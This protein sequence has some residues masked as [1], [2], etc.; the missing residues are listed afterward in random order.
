MGSKL[1]QINR[2]AKHTLSLHPFV[3]VPALAEDE[4]FHSSADEEDTVWCLFHFVENPKDISRRFNSTFLKN[5]CKEQF[6]S[7]LNSPGYKPVISALFRYFGSVF[8]Y[9][10]LWHFFNW[11]VS[12]LALTAVRHLQLCVAQLNSSKS[13]KVLGLGRAELEFSFSI[14]EEKNSMKRKQ[15]HGRRKEGKEVV[16]HKSGVQGTEIL[17]G[18]QKRAYN[19]QS[20][21]HSNIFMHRE[22]LF[23]LWQRR[24]H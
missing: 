15:C 2:R 23:V 7:C 5:Q 16:R 18:G 14:S 19:L 3:P 22:N 20:C 10:Y 9:L 21:F 6:R 12:S 11:T 13:W 17:M 8:F 1:K 24:N 4:G